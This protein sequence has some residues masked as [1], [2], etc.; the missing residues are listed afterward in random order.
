MSR[1]YVTL[2][3]NSSMDCYPEN[4]VARF[5]TKLNA[6]IELE[7]DWNVGLTERYP[8]LPTLKTCWTVTVTTPSAST[9]GFPA[10]IALEAKHYATNRDFVREM[11]AK[12]QMSIGDVDLFV[13]F[14]VSKGKVGRSS[15]SRT[16]K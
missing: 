7:G 5:T 14:F 16:S 8:F 2:P 12:Q 6:A 10:K 4:S 15:T 3:S 13:E 11:N 9:T 1:F